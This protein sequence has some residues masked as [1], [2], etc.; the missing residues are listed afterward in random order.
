MQHV[1]IKEKSW[2][3]KIGAKLL[4]VNNVALTIGHTIYLYNA[5]KIE[6][7]LN[8]TWLCHE[9]VH[10]KQ[11][12]QLGVAKFLFLYI[13]EWIAKGYLNNKFEV[14]ARAK[15]TNL[16]LLNDFKVV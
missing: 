5:T 14:E 13:K 2:I 8:K 1:Y 10:V 11:Y 3:A 7:L 6:L 15:E 9:L 4:G 16:N 12:Q